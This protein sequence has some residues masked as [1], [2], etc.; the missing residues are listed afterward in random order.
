M[1][2][3]RKPVALA[4]RTTGFEAMPDQSANGCSLARVRRTRAG[5]IMFECIP[6]AAMSRAMMA[7]ETFRRID[8]G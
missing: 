6:L 8:H 5:R 4:S 1:G 7:L 2:G 3:Q